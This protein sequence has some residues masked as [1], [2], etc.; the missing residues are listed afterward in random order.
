MPA[1]RPHTTNRRFLTDAAIYGF[2]GACSQIV[3]VLLLPLYTGFLSPSEFGVLEIIDRVTRVINICLMTGGIAQAAMAFY[4]QAE[5]KVERER[6]AASV[7]LLLLICFVVACS[8]TIAIAPALSG[9]LQIDDPGLFVFGVL[10]FLTQLAMIIP[11]TLMQARLES[12]AYV[13]VCLVMSLLRVALAILFVAFWGWGLYGIYWSILITSVGFGSALT[14]RELRLGSVRVDWQRC[15]EMAL[16]SVPFLPTGLMGFVMSTSDRFFLL[17][18]VDIAAV[19][20]YALGAKIAA[21][22]GMFTTTPLFQVWT[23]RMYTELK[24]PGGS[25]YGGRMLTHMLVAYGLG[26]MGICLFHQEALSLMNSSKFVGAGSIIAPL[27]LANGFFF[28]SNFMECAFY[29]QR[30]TSLK[31]VTALVSTSV[32]LALYALLIPR[33]GIQ[34]AAYGTLLGCAAKVGV[35]YVIAQRVLH[36][37]Y[38]LG[39]IVTLLAI[40]VICYVPTADWEMAPQTFLAKCGIMMAWMAAIW[41]GTLRR[42]NRGTYARLRAADLKKPAN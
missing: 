22:V 26:G 31:P 23:A 5:D 11:L 32:T 24:R 9:W 2:G 4:L 12:V 14:I 37:H 18:S 19:G 39:A 10:A 42:F 34:G 13:S 7:A 38:D 1:K 3:S 17:T 21:A 36:I 28:M 33:Y 35:T 6:V 15:K 29:V 30:R 8:L 16:F 20:I 41:F 27:V 40:S 25:E